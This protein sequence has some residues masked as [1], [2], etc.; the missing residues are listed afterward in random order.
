MSFEIPVF[1]AVSLLALTVCLANC[2]P[3]AVDNSSAT[4]NDPQ[5]VA[6]ESAAAGNPL[7]ANFQRYDVAACC[8]LELPA[9]STEITPGTPI[10]S[11]VAKVF[12]SGSTRIDIDLVGRNGLAPLSQPQTRRDQ[13]MDGI[14]GYVN[15]LSTPTKV[16]DRDAVFS[17]TVI[18]EDMGCPIAERIFSSVMVN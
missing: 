18:C 16:G 15:S 17:V 9:D 5:A 10:D 11:I 3:M 14:E 12:E 6:T 13:L 8:S 7:S 2:A 4:A 1:R